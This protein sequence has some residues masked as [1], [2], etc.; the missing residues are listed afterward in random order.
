MQ[1]NPAPELQTHVRETQVDEKALGLERTVQEKV[2][3]GLGMSKL[4]VEA[5]L[6]YPKAMCHWLEEF[7]G[8][9]MHFSMYR[10]RDPV[11][12]YEGSDQESEVSTS[13]SAKEEVGR[14]AEE[15]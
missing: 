4:L 3:T 7:L 9:V 10:N 5:C 6:E 12:D 14:K 1:S 8:A 2:L 13:S 15:S 11:S